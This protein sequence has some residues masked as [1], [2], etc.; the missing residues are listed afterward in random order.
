MG[1]VQSVMRWHHDYHSPDFVT[2]SS[3]EERVSGL[4]Q[5]LYLIYFK[6]RRGGSDNLCPSALSRLIVYEYNLGG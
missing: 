6:Y 4:F 1:V 2:L 3:L 5:D